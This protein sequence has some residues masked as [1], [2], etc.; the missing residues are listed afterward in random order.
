MKEHFAYMGENRKKLGKHFL[1]VILATFFLFL[2]D[3]E[4]DFL[5]L[6]ASLI[7]GFLLAWFMNR[8][9]YEKPVWL[10]VSIIALLV[11]IGSFVW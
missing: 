3:N 6:P 11:Y 10:I 4:I 7:I 2:L 5:A 8:D 1:W 9:L